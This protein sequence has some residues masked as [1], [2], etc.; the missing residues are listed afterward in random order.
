MSSSFSA[1]S[2][3]GAWWRQA[4]HRFPSAIGQNR[5]RG[6]VNVQVTYSAGHEASASF[7][8]RKRITN[9]RLIPVLSAV[10][11]V[12]LL[13]TCDDKP[14][15]TQET[16]MQKGEEFTTKVTELATSNPEKVAALM[17]KLQQV[18]T[19]AQAAGEEDLAASCAALDELMAELNK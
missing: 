13:A 10:M 9:M 4:D 8:D 19:E 3:G 18:L 12:G 5:P 2:G 17:P 7:F 6:I 1:H 11:A 14:E 15:C 16:V